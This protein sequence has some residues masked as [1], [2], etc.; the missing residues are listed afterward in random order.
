MDDSGCRSLCNALGFFDCLEDSEL[1]LPT[2]NGAVRLFRF[3]GIQVYLHWSWFVVALIEFN[4]R[5]AQYSSP[6]WNV[7]EYLA[8][9]VIVLM[10]EFG[11][12]LACRQTG[13]QADQIVLWPLG[14][15]AYVAPPPR[16]AATLWSIAAGPLVNLILL[17]I[18]LV[19]AMAADGIGLKDS[20]PNLRHFLWALVYINAGLLVFNLLPVY[21]LDGGQ[22]L[23]SLLW[24]AIGPA[25]SLIVATVIGLAGAATLAGLALFQGSIWIGV[26]AAFMGIN[27]WRALQHARLLRQVEQA[28]AYQGARCPKCQAPP[29]IGAFWACGSC[30]TRFDTFATGGVCPKCHQ[31]FPITACIQCGASRPMSEWLGQPAPPVIHPRGTAQ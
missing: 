29:L 23:R 12:A 7:A 6:F 21:P 27:C 25:R 2:Q 15:V 1:V 14:G 4:L 13:G 18:A 24:F 31:Q 30:Q 5:G 28:P 3:S 19:V 17:P 10:H 11:H 20:M 26:L 9:F 22:I 8:L 16:P